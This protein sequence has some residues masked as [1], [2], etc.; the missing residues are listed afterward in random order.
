[1]GLAS[2]P[3]Q[4]RLKQRSYRLVS[5]GLVSF[6][7]V[8]GA[9]TQL[10]SLSWGDDLRLAVDEAR[11]H[12][13]SPRANSHA[14]RVLVDAVGAGQRHLMDDAVNFLEKARVTNRRSITPEIAMIIAG[15]RLGFPVGQDWYDSAMEKLKAGNTTHSSTFGLFGLYQCLKEAVHCTRVDSNIFLLFKTAGGSNDHRAV[16]LYGLFL[17]DI[18]GMTDAAEVQYRNAISRFP[19][20]ALPS[21]A[22]A[23]VMI[24]NKA[25]EE[26]LNEINSAK[27]KD[28]YGIHRKE[29]HKAMKIINSRRDAGSGD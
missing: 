7:L 19:G 14:G 26:A 29:I 8:T 22:L 4:L 6:L 10:R 13:D 20:Q 18:L 23:R 17:E 12:P 27:A 25:W 11:H 15:Q 5:I 28:R 21:I 16:V 1:M 2:L 3:F 24:K 9:T